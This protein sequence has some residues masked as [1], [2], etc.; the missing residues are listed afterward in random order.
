MQAQ[1]TRC[2][3]A[4]LAYMAYWQAK[5]HHFPR[6]AVIPEST[7]TPPPSWSLPTRTVLAVSAVMLAIS[8]AILWV[9]Q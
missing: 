1:A 6:G 2:T 7:T 5:G 8:Y 4:Q 9:A 3:Q